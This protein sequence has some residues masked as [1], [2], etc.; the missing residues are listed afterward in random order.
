LQTEK[1]RFENQGAGIW[2]NVVPHPEAKPSY[3]DDNVAAQIRDHGGE[4]VSVWDI[5]ESGPFVEIE[6]HMIWRAPDGRLLD[7]SPS[8]LGATRHFVIPSLAP[9]TRP[10][11]GNVLLPLSSDPRL[12]E[13]AYYSSLANAVI[14][15]NRVPGQMIIRTDVLRIWA[16]DFVEKEKVTCDM[17]KLVSAC[18]AV[19]VS[20]GATVS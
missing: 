4:P 7:V 1:L 3:C 15:P 13:F 2:V 5:T 17:G 16:R 10:F 11:P 9:F 18:L 8:L 12:R 14:A 20:R 19:L 6:A